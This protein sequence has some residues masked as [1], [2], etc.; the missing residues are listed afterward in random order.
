MGRW[1]SGKWVGGLV[2]RRSMVGDFK[3]TCCCSELS[4]MFMSKC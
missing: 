3:R 1:L 2:V 4:S